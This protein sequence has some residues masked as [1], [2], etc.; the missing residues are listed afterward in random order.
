VTL[1]ILLDSHAS[2][3]AEPAP[4]VRSFLRAAVLTS[5]LVAARVILASHPPGGIAERDLRKARVAVYDGLKAAIL[6][7]T[8]R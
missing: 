6:Q 3:V 4:L 2:D 8:H 7:E 5:T 1:L